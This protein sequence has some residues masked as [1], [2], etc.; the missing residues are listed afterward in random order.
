MTVYC[1]KFDCAFAISKLP[2]M[3]EDC[4]EIF[5]RWRCKDVIKTGLKPKWVQLEFNFDGGSDEQ[6][7]A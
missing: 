2:D 7:E 4:T 6:K 3:C 1:K 5:M